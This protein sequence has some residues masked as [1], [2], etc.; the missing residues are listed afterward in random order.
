MFGAAIFL[1]LIMELRMYDKF[2]KRDVNRPWKRHDIY[3]RSGHMRL[4]MR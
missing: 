3:M 1:V 4:Q 2:E